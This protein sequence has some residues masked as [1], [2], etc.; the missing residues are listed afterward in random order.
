MTDSV[1]KNTIVRKGA[2]SDV[3]RLRREPILTRLLK[4]PELGALSGVIFVYLIFYLVAG[5]SGMFSPKGL[6]E[7]MQSSSELG[8]LAVAAALLMIAGEFDL[9]IGSMIGFAGCIIG[10]SV[11]YFHLPLALAIACTFFIC[12]AIG[13]MNGWLTVRT[14]LP[15]FIVTLAS[16]FI[17][18]GETIADTRYLNTGTVITHITTGEPD[19]FMISLFGGRVGR[20]LFT[21]LGQNHWIDV[22]NKGLPTITGVPVSILWWISLTMLATWVLLRTRFGNWIFAVGGE[23]TSAH[24]VGVPVDR[25]KII[26]FTMTAVSAALFAAFQIMQVG[27]TDTG[28][29]LNK[30]FE[31]I[32]AAVIGGNLLTGGYGSAIGAFLGS[33]IYGTVQLGINYAGVDADRFKVFM[34]GMVLMAVL[35]NNYVRRRAT[36]SR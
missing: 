32:I 23:K 4:R 21:W 2:G 1:A 17:L 26:L 15:S 18:R 30:E 35:F 9:S 6:I 24:N 19:S 11:T 22:N 13:A 8:V 36:L 33:L 7:I 5:H 14:G 28:R 3:L 16:M 25:V 27:S 12:G 29:G 31:P 34:G 10:L 20:S